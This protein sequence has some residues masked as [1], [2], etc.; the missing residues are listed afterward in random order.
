MNVIVQIAV[1]HIAVRSPYLCE[2]LGAGKSLRRISQKRLQQHAFPPGQTAVPLRAVQPVLGNIIGQIS[3]GDRLAEGHLPGAP[4]DA[5]DPGHQFFKGKRLDQIV[6]RSGIQ[7]F[8]FVV[9]FTQGCD[10][11]DRDLAA[12]APDPAKHL[13]AADAR[14]HSIQQDQIMNILLHVIQRF[15]SVHTG[16]YLEPFFFQLKSQGLIQ[17]FVVFHQQKSHNATFNSLSLRSSQK[18]GRWSRRSQTH[19]LFRQ[20]R[21]RLQSVYVRLHFP[22]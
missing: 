3:A 21:A 10:Q 13:H 12:G 18:Y 8:D 1:F 19:I 20:R 15:F 22:P 5:A 9:Q 11:N 16:V 17:F 2:Q 4:G 6:V 14:K 7:P